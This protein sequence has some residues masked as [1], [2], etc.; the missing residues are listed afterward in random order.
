M[1]NW[2]QGER[3]VETTTF[4]SDGHQETNEW[5]VISK[6]RVKVIQC[7]K[8]FGSYLD[9]NKEYDLEPHDSQSYLQLWEIDVK[10][11]KRPDS[12]SQILLYDWLDGPD[13]KP[14]MEIDF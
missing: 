3:I 11:T 1:I 2:Q 10:N 8:H 12:C 9:I 5:E 13:A 4:V 6:G 7:T 14:S